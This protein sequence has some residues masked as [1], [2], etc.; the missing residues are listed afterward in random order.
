MDRDIARARYQ[1]SR[2]RISPCSLATLLATNSEDFTRRLR[3]LSSQM[4]NYY[5]SPGETIHAS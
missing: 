1:A 3:E 4:G 2:R 5:P